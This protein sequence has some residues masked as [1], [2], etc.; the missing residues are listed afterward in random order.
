MC[1]AT[2]VINWRVTA[3][4]S[5]YL[6]FV[7]DLCFIL[8]IFYNFIYQNRTV[9]LHR[10]AKTT[11]S[12]LLRL[13]IA[14]DKKIGIRN[15]FSM[16]TMVSLIRLLYQT[17]LIDWHSDILITSMINWIKVYKEFGTTSVCQDE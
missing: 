5:V 6:I 1:M 4:D 11:L 3:C 12:D 2:K 8:I 9:T 14:Q 15:P 13:E 7:F 17:S 10:T 16:F